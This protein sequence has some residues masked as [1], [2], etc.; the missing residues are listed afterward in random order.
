[1]AEP[2]K[3]PAPVPAPA[4]ANP[5]KLMFIMMGAMFLLLMMGMGGMFFALKGQSSATGTPQTAD[6]KKAVAKQ[7]A[8]DKADKAT[9]AAKDKGPAKYVAFDPPFVVN[10][11]ADSPVKFLQVSLQV[12]TR[13]DTMARQMKDNDP[14]IRNA[15]LELLDGQNY[16]VL[17]TS[18]GKDKL[19]QD[20]LQKIRD[21]MKQEGS[22]P[23]KIE[24]VYFTAFVMQ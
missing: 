5:N 22:D 20:A 8:K 11:K 13:D 10:F 7:E 2:T 18:A 15:I 9:E 4:A 23:T 17:A 12:M 3:V 16:E 6:A 19:R 21:V 14:A 24:A 1:M